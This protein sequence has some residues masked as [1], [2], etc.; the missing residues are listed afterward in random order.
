QAASITEAPS[1]SNLSQ[2]PL[3]TAPAPPATITLCPSSRVGNSCATVSVLPVR[4]MHVRSVPATQRILDGNRVARLQLPHLLNRIAAR[5]QC[6][7][8]YV[9]QLLCEK[10]GVRGI[11]S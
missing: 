6:P 8:D 7:S 4:Q 5:I 1:A 9:A 2:I 3:P 10:S 11:P